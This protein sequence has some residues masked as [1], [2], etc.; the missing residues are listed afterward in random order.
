MMGKPLAEKVNEKRLSLGLD[1]S[2]FLTLKFRGK[3]GLPF[4]V[5]DLYFYLT[6]TKVDLSTFVYVDPTLEIVHDRA[7][8]AQK[9]KAEEIE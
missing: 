3:H 1:C 8:I 5:Q 7:F 9:A 2:K 4:M 6:A